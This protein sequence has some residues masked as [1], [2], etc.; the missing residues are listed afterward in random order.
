VPASRRFWGHARQLR[1]LS[2]NVGGSFGMKS[3]VFPEY[4]CVLH[5]ARLLAG[6]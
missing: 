5:A 3:Q 4:P 1:V 2:Y 6:R